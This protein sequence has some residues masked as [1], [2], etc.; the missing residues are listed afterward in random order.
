[1]RIDPA[2]IVPE[3]AAPPYANEPD[4]VRAEPTTVD[5]VR[6]AFG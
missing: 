6:Q 1:M 3:T 2:V 5:D 4:G